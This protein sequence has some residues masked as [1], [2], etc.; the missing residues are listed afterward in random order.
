VLVCY[1]VAVSYRTIEVAW[2]P[3]TTTA[4]ATFSAS[5]KAAARLWNDLVVR[6]QRIRRLAWRWPSK[7]RWQRWA[8]GRYPGLSAQSAQQIIGEFCEAVDSCRQLRTNGHAQA[9]YPWK[10]RRYHDVVYTNQD[11]RIRDG[12]LVLP[13]GTSGTLRIRLPDAVTLPGRL[14]EVRLSYGLVRLICEVPDV[15]RTQQ[16][17]IGVDLGV[18]TLVAATD[19]RT[20]ILISGRAAKATVQYRNKQLARLQQAQSACTRHSRRYKRLQRRKYAMLEKTKRRIRDLCHQATRQVAQAFPNATCYVGEPFNDAAQRIGRKQA[21][22]VST[23]CTRKIIQLLDYK[24]AGAITLGEAYSS[25]TCPV[26]GE[27]SKH[28]RIYRCPH[29]GATGPRDAVGALNILSLGMHGAMLPGRR[30]PQRVKY[31]RPWPRQP[32]SSSGGHP[33]RSSA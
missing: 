21:Q 14:M 24:T 25:Q 17:I 23:A 33:A 8:K 10:L 3:R 1:T 32:R 16:A 4:W 30:L 6:H 11:A 13:H 26:C 9:R 7:A 18:N 19:G 5:R 2:H 12:R 20:V 31:L 29:C 22:Q 15:A 28:R 27:R